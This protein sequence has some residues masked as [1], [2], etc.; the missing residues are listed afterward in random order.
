MKNKDKDI[1]R[2]DAEDAMVEVLRE[3]QDR[4][5]WRELIRKLEQAALPDPY[6]EREVLHAPLM[7]KAAKHI[8]KLEQEVQRLRDALQEIADGKKNLGWSPCAYIA[9][10]ALKEV[11]GG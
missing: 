8:Q 1:L 6:D 4:N 11:D 5:G 7:N 10:Q 9:E 2:Q 3:E